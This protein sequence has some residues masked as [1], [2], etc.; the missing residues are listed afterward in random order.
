MGEMENERTTNFSKFARCSLSDSWVHSTAEW[1]KEA[2]RHS[3]SSADFLACPSAMLPNPSSV[4]NY[5]V[6]YKIPQHEPKC[7]KHYL[8]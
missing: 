5:D 2:P 8:T 1:P 7:Y 6:R 4:W 3:F